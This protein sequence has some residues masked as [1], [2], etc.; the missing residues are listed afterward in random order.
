MRR[1]DLES[2]IVRLWPRIQ[3]LLDQA[4]LV[5]VHPDRLEAIKF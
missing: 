1:L 2:L 4:D 3:A 5:E